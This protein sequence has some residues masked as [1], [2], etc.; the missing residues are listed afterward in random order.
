MLLGLKE[1]AEKYGHVAKPAIDGDPYSSAHMC[2]DVRHG[3]S[4]HEYHY[5]P[6]QL[7]DDDYLEA[8]AAAL[9]GAVHEPANRRSLV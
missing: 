7:S 3:W 1:L 4:A 6:V 5:G 8:L 9:T 2:A